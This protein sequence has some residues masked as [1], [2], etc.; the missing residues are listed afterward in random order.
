M[1]VYL[2]LASFVYSFNHTDHTQISGLRCG[3]TCAR[4]AELCRP[5]CQAWVEHVREL[6]RTWLPGDDRGEQEAV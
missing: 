5:R 2:I 3:W 4:A 6:R 1:P